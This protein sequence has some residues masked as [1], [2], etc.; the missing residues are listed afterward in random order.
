MTYW[1]YIR[2]TSWIITC[3]ISYIIWQY[4]SGSLK[5]SILVHHTCSGN[6]GVIFS[7]PR[8]YTNVSLRPGPVFSSCVLLAVC[9]YTICFV[10]NLVLYY[11]VIY[12]IRYNSNI[13]RLIFLLII[14]S[15]YNN[16]AA[17]IIYNPVCL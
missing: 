16:Q 3:H 2:Y 4:F 15:A 13:L 11:Q 7:R 12:H 6:Q 10:L 5:L 8:M 1:Y 14:N 17:P 9:I